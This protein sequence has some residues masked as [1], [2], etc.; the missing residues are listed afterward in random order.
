MSDP[1]TPT[2]PE[3]PREQALPAHVIEDARS[4]RSRCKGC[5]RT[6]QKGTLR[7]GILFEGPYGTGYLWHHLTCAA[8]RR[9]EELEEA[10]A[11]EA[12]KAAKVPPSNVPP[13]E[14]LKSSAKD[15]EE[16]R[17]QRRELPYAEVDPSGRAKCKHCDGKLE[18]GSLRV[19]LGRRV[20]FGNQ[21]RTSA[22]NVHPECV[23]EAMA[24]DDC[25]TKSEDFASRL[26]AHS[27]ELDPGQIEAVLAAIGELP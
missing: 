6:I 19:A 14:D 12:W 15:A 25:D 3:G 10:Y 9:P 21:V 18:Q 24:A 26:G 4:G 7:L 17:E 5:R 13:L 2:Q 22:I 1:P 20:E 27:P 16:R 11:A 8:R 23:A